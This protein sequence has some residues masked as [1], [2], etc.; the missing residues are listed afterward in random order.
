MT[1]GKAN[2]TGKARQSRPDHLLRPHG[3]VHPWEDLEWLHPCATGRRGAPLCSTPGVKRRFPFLAPP[4]SFALRADKAAHKDVYWSSTP[5]VFADPI[6]RTGGNLLHATFSRRY[7]SK[8]L[9]GGTTDYRGVSND[10]DYVICWGCPP[11]V[12]AVIERE[13]LLV[14]KNGLL[15]VYQG[16]SQRTLWHKA[17]DCSAAVTNLMVSNVALPGAGP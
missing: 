14:F 8:F 4:S 6:V 5:Y 1:G 11:A 3:N 17:D 13:G 15:S 16:S 2:G 12:T 7:T 9:G 10:Y